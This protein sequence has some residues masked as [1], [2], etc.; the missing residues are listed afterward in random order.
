L[1]T[2]HRNNKRILFG[3][4]DFDVFNGFF[5][6]RDIH[7]CARDAMA[8][9]TV[10]PPIFHIK[11]LPQYALTGCHRASMACWFFVL[12]HSRCACWRVGFLPSG[13]KGIWIIA[14]RCAGSS[15]ARSRLRAT[16]SCT[17]SRVSL[18]GGQSCTAK[19]LPARQ[20][21]VSSFRS[22]GVGLVCG[23]AV[24]THARYQLLHLTVSKSA[25]KEW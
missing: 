2:R 9:R 14:I 11:A 7:F 1:N 18:D 13:A 23:E 8:G 17:A 25:S 22:A 4:D 6:H 3:Q 5:S 10:Q 24:P 15:A 16:A 20:S 19:S 12:S 21:A